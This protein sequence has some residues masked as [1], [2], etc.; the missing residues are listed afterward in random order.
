WPGEAPERRGLLLALGRALAYGQQAGHEVLAEARA[1]FLAT[2]RSEQAALA[3]TL[4][5]HLARIRPQPQQAAAHVD[6]ALA[7]PVRGTRAEVEAL[8]N[9]AID[10]LL[11]DQHTAATRVATQAARV[12]EA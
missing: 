8:C 11:A 5:S 12:A 3:E 4:L 1:G 2:G 7:R 6:Q 10:H 9:R